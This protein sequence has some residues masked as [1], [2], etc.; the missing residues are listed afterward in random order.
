MLKV[1]PDDLT[2]LL[3]LTAAVPGT[4]PVSVA[5]GVRPA[6]G[7]AWKRVAID[8]TPPYRAFLEP[9]AYRRGARLQAVA[10][11]RALDGRTAA[12][13]VV[14]FTIRRG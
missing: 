3:R 2:E 14:A 4:S 5:F 7:G 8:D 10:V 11:V 6:S 9:G 13:R 1:G 12:S